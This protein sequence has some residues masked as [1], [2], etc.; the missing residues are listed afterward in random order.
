VDHVPVHASFAIAAAV[1]LL[2]VCG[3]IHLVGG[4]ALTRIALPAQLGYMVLFSYSFFFDGMSGLT[5]TIGAI[6]TL[7]ILML[8]SARV[9]WSEKFRRKP[10]AAAPPAVV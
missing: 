7:A 9:D 2:L 8:A 4:R 5:I 3:Y 1:S 10:R 6:L